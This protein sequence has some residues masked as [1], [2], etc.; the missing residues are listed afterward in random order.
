MGGARG[1]EMHST[2]EGM[3]GAS[4]E[5]KRLTRPLA[6]EILRI[7]V[8]LPVTLCRTESSEALM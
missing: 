2:R 4:S 1:C 5:I 8:Q 6:L 7:L 3:N